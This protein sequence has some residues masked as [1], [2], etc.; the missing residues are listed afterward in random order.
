VGLS[1]KSWLVFIDTLTF[2]DFRFHPVFL[3]GINV[4]SGNKPLWT[5]PA[6]AKYIVFDRRRAE[7]YYGM[8]DVGMP[9][10]FPILSLLVRWTFFQE[11]ISRVSCHPVMA[12]AFPM[13]YEE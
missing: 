10:F 12:T 11:T 6:K 7:K 13:A 4:L 1:S 3:G 8:T 2:C 5:L 9:D